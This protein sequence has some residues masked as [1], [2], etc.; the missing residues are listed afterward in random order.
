[1]SPGRP[2]LA[3]DDWHATAGEILPQPRAEISDF[4]QLFVL[5]LTAASAGRVDQGGV[6]SPEAP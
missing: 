3:S 2:D 4:S 6:P 5:W 1:M